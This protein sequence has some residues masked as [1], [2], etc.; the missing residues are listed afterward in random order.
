M[1]KKHTRL[2]LD[3]LGKISELARHGLTIAAIAKISDR[4]DTAVGNALKD[5]GISTKVKDRTTRQLDKAF[6]LL[7]QGIRP[8]QYSDALRQRRSTS[9]KPQQK[10][11]RLSWL[12]RRLNSIDAA[13]ARRQPAPTKVHQQQELD[14]SWG[15]EMQEFVARLGEGRD[16]VIED[17]RRRVKDILSILDIIIDD[18]ARKKQ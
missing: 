4:S 17:L 15:I 1:P 2:D 3:E 7:R 6:A 14:Q 18:T 10:G 11:G 9:K 8:M 13:R 16:L 12:T 5:L